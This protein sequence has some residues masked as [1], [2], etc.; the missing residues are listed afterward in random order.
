MKYSSTISLGSAE[1]GCP[2]RLC[3]RYPPSSAWRS[4]RRLPASEHFD[5][6]Q[7][8]AF[9]DLVD[10]EGDA[11][12]AQQHDGQPAAEVL[13]ELLEAAQD[14]RLIAGPVAEFSGA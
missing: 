11:D 2:F 1:M 7:H 6:A 4:L 5:A 10:V 13:A 12:R 3:S 14:G 8:N 9:V